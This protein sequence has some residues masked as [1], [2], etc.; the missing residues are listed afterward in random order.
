MSMRLWESDG[1]TPLT[2][3]DSS[4][5]IFFP[6]I[7]LNIGDIFSIVKVWKQNYLGTPRSVSA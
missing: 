2:L 3:L 1:I 6:S 4:R 7:S 5:I